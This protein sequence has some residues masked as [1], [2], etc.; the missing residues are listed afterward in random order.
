MLEDITQQLRT[1]KSRDELMEVI[2]SDPELT[3]EQMA[4]VLTASDKSKIKDALLKEFDALIPLAIKY[5]VLTESQAQQ[6]RKESITLLDNV[7]TLGD[8]F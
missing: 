2:N 4:Y 1:V 8:L 3:E 5:N 7:T 6:N